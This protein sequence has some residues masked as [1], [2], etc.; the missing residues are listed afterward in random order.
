M[1]DR[2]NNYMIK[3]IHAWPVQLHEHACVCVR[4]RVRVR[5]CVCVRASVCAWQRLHGRI[6]LHAK[7]M[8]MQTCSNPARGYKR[9][10]KPHANVHLPAWGLLSTCDAHTAT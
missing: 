2:V 7:C 5:V 4:V 8:Y 3:C 1:H 6:L 9:P 10:F